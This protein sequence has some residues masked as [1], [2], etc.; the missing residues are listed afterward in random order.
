[1]GSEVRD[2]TDSDRLLTDVQMEET[3]DLAGTVELCAPFLE[4][5]HTEHLSVEVEPQL[6]V[7]G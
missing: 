2:R 4:T 3:T 5:P 1:M 6:T 7:D